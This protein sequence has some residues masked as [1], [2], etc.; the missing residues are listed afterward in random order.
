MLHVVDDELRTRLG[1]EAGQSRHEELEDHRADGR[2]AAAEFDFDVVCA[3]WWLDRALRRWE[4][5]LEVRAT[6][7]VDV[8]AAGFTDGLQV[9]SGDSRL[10]GWDV[11]VHLVS[12]GQADDRQID[13]LFGE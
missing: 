4:D 3:H 10:A 6:D 11:P 12:S 13:Q 9:F 8:D 5:R 1:H 7:Q 2:A